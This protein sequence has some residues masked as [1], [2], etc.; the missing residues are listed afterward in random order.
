MTPG[1]C[2]DDLP[3]VFP[4]K[5]HRLTVAMIADGGITPWSDQLDRAEELQTGFN[6]AT[7]LHL[8]DAIEY[9]LGPDG[10]P[11]SR[12]DQGRS[13]RILQEHLDRTAASDTECRWWMRWTDKPFYRISQL[14]QALRRANSPNRDY[15]ITIVRA[16]AE[17][18][19]AH[20]PE[21]I[22]DRWHAQGRP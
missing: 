5:M 21:D 13:Q 4:S 3:T 8:V 12:F 15:N 18:A 11:L 1:T 22:V 7:L 14:R 17:K 6:S 16:A 19:F 9:G 10:S 20:V 2:V